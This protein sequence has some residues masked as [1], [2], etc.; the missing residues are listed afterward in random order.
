MPPLHLPTVTILDAV[1]A[2]TPINCGKVMA[3]SKNHARRPLLRL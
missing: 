1:A 2:K 3:I